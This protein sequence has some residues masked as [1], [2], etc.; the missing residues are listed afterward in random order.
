MALSQQLRMARQNMDDRDDKSMLKARAQ[1]DTEIAKVDEDIA[2]LS[3]LIEEERKRTGT[4]LDDLFVDT[5]SEDEQETS[6]NFSDF[7]I[8]DDDEEEEDMKPIL[9]KEEMERF[10]EEVEEWW[11]NVKQANDRWK[12]SSLYRYLATVKAEAN[13]TWESLIEFP[14]DVLES[15]DA[16]A[17]EPT[18]EQRRRA[19]AQLASV[20]FPSGT[21]TSGTGLADIALGIQDPEIRARYERY[22]R[23]K[24]HA[25]MLKFL[26]NPAVVGDFSQVTKTGDLI[27]W[28]QSALSQ[29]TLA[30]GGWHLRK[31]EAESFYEDRQVRTLFAQLVARVSVGAAASE[32]LRLN[33][34]LDD[35]I[36]ET[37]NIIIQLRRAEFTHGNT[38][39]IRD[40]FRRKPRERIAMPPPY[41]LY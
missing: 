41:V 8:A 24:G 28:E 29:L 16:F 36:Q 19:A 27:G 15:I 4:E 21:T 10:V 35:V 22:L 6:F 31:A 39:V 14:T 40:E 13:L 30:R 33:R 37:E 1:L 9:N 2:N 3:A 5:E 18:P 11:T 12:G 7:L 38:L 17:W 34:V 32:G 20:T 26:S 23:L 25:A